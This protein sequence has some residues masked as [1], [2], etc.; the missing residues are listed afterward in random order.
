MYV[1]D[2]VEYPIF[3]LN[4]LVTSQNLMLSDKNLE[5]ENKDLCKRF[6]YVQ[7]CKKATWHRRRKEYIK[8]LRRRHNM[9]NKD[10]KTK[11]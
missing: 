2:D 6:K 1:E 8:S 9:K 7:K 5:T 3:T 10:P 11:N 4:T